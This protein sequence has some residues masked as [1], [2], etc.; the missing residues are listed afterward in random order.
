MKKWL[1]ARMRRW[2][3]AWLCIAIGLAWLPAPAEAAGVTLLGMALPSG[4][5]VTSSGSAGGNLPAYVN[6]GNTATYWEANL[7]NP[8]FRV[9]LPSSTYITGF[10]IASSAPAAG[11]F[12]T[13]VKHDITTDWVQLGSGSFAVDTEPTARYYPITPGYYQKLGLFTNGYARINEIRYFN[14]NPPTG[15]TAVPAPDAVEL[16][17][18]ADPSP[19]HDH[20]R[21]YKDGNL[22]D[23]TTSTSYTI[24]DLTEGQSH[25]FYVTSA[26]GS[27]G[28]SNA[29][30]TVSAAAA[31]WA[32]SIGLNAA[33]TEAEHGESVTLTATVTPAHDS[34][35]DTVAFYDNGSLIGT[36]EVAD[37]N[38]EISAAMLGTGS[39]TLT[40]SYSGT[41][42]YEPSDSQP[43]TVNVV[44]AQTTVTLDDIAAPVRYGLPITLSAK[45]ESQY[46]EVP[47]GPVG[48]HADGA[49]LG[50]AH[51]NGAGIASLTLEGPAWLDVGT[52][53]IDAEYAGDTD[54]LTASSAVQAIEIQPA[55][56]STVL[57]VTPLN[58][59]YGDTV[60]LIAAVTPEG[61]GSP[62]GSVTFTNGA[63]SSE[64]VELNNGIAVW[65]T[66]ELQLGTQEWTASYGGDESYSASSSAGSTVTVG[67]GFTNTSLTPSQ[68][69]ATY[70][71]SVTFTSTV[72]YW[73]EAIPTGSVM[74]T[75][76]AGVSETVELD[77][78]AAATF[79]TDSLDAGYYT[80]TA[81]YAGDARYLTSSRELGI[82]IDQAEPLIALQ[83]S[84]S[85]IT[86][87]NTVTFE[88]ALAFDGTAL[89][90]KTVIFKSGGITLGTDTTDAD[91]I[92]RFETNALTAGSHAL[93]AEFAGSLNY[94]AVE[95]S[96]INVTVTQAVPALSLSAS[97]DHIAYGDTVSLTAALTVY[98]AALEGATII[99]NDGA[100]ML[101]MG[102]TDAEGIAT[103]E[104]DGLSASASAHA[105]TASYG[106]DENYSAVVSAAVDIAVTAAE[107][108][109]HA[110]ELSVSLSDQT[111]VHGQ[112]VTVTASLTSEGEPVTS[113]VILL[114]INGQVPIALELFE[115][116]ASYT[117]EQVGAGALELT[118]SFEETDLHYAAAANVSLVVGPGV[119]AIDANEDGI[120]TL[121]EIVKL[122]AGDSPYKDMNGDGIV[123][124]DDARLAL[125][126]I[127]SIEAALAD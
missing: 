104:T 45:V 77:E 57:T 24:G 32:S 76:G 100:I 49:L 72:S 101:G 37:G 87:G 97:A 64:S 113:G 33:A 4:T 21:V 108:V 109:K 53:Q 71:E 36:A 11:T 55:N 41:A 103:I 81:V 35:S 115:G 47:T 44:P 26:N 118:A 39:H 46:G 14:T 66:A 127:E 48:F 43:V 93:T 54:Y 20:Y 90:S 123:D 91:G 1:R 59:K 61:G 68:E 51:V 8:W 96:A 114:A 69:T 84:S 102:V 94:K 23:T 56:S 95:S 7:P 106:G 105:V 13:D 122:F 112:S 25:A 40:A 85:A 107:I 31:K 29:S 79:T 6:D 110:T 74:F 65:T 125:Q 60:T 58:S 70:G 52:H 42:E 98:G 116:T 121:A 120:A 124:A 73:G 9:T 63:D 67:K 22:V 83:T 28:E 126:A 16:T 17:W 12:S 62:T 78:H 119:L 10:Q 89:P 15:L 38:A 117:I 111:A 50:A 82:T 5:A 27:G 92:A 80:I 19:M 75:N 86:Y 2:G 30:V 88:A 34:S 99:F 18:N 3:L